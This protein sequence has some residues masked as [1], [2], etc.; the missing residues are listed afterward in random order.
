MGC[1]IHGAVEATTEGSSYWRYVVDVGSVVGRSYDTFGALWGVR[2]YGMFEPA[3][4]NRGFPDELSLSTKAELQ[5][6]GGD[7]YRNELGRLDFH[8]ASWA[9]MD[10]MHAL[11]WD[12][13]A[14]DLDHRISILDENKTPTGSKAGGFGPASGWYEILEDDDARAAL[15]RGEPVPNESG[16]RYIQRRLL[17]RRDTLTPAWEWLIFTM[18]P[19][20]G[21]RYDDVRMVVWF[22]N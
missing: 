11:D 12:E 2:N 10:E 20:I 3:F 16:T 14:D 4:A 22:D 9:T 7:D 15:D 18:L 6:W 8:S 1:D 17:T 5:S 21:E 19:A 13:S